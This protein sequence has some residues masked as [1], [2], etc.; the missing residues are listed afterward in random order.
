MIL[1]DPPPPGPR[2]RQPPVQAPCPGSLLVGPQA[3]AAQLT[4]GGWPL[5]ASA[6]LIA[7]NAGLINHAL[8]NGLLNGVLCAEFYWTVSL[9]FAVSNSVLPVGIYHH[10]MYSMPLFV[11]RYDEAVQGAPS[12]AAHATLLHG[13]LAIWHASPVAQDRE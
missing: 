10:L 9:M 4:L 13:T 12:P 8:A 11:K 7:A 1:R 5:L 6:G 2:C 3:L